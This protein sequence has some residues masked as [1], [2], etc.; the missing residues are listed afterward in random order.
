MALAAVLVL[1]AL[2]VLLVSGLVCAAACKGCS[3]K[4]K[5]SALVRAP[6]QAAPS[7]L[8]RQVLAAR[9]K[10]KRRGSSA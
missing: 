5:A 2:L 6:R 3:S 7:L 10:A 8:V 9:G 1:L 4:V